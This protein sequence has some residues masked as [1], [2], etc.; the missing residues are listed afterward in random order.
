LLPALPDSDFVKGVLWERASEVERWEVLLPDFYV[1]AYK[2][3]GP[4]L[5]RDGAEVLVSQGFTTEEYLRRMADV[6]PKGFSLLPPS[7]LNF[8]WQED[9][10]LKASWG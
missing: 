9:G 2:S 4:M 7:I 8:T 3:N 5:P 6:K 10:T 1:R